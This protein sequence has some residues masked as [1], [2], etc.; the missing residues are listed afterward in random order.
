MDLAGHHLAESFVD[1]AMS[2]DAAQPR[3]CRT[4]DVHGEMS[5]TARLR[6]S[7]VAGTL[8]VDPDLER[9]ETLTEQ[10]L[11]P[12]RACHKSSG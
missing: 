10:G 12:R 6:V 9:A 7:R 3:E 2:R 4:H 5:A 8:V 11:D 1:Q